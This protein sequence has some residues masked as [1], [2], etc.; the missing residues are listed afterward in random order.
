MDMKY[1]F[2]KFAKDVK[3]LL[4]LNHVAF[5]KYFGI[6]VNVTAVS[7]GPY[8]STMYI[9]PLYY[10]I[11]LGDEYT[12][13]VVYDRNDETPYSAYC[14]GTGNIISDGHSLL[15]IK[16][17]CFVWLSEIIDD[18]ESGLIHPFDSSDD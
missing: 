8:E 14:S 3:E 18:L 12:L 2:C 11:R 16:H 9:I 5:E 1:E 6:D 13:Q 4:E 7:N 15:D 10:G 17:D